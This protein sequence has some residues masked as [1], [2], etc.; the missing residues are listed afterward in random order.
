MN[1]ELFSCPECGRQYNVSHVPSCAR[2][3]CECGA[4]PKVYK[5]TPH[6]PRAL[7]CWNCGGSF[8]PHAHECSYCGSDFTI[9]E[10]RLNAVCP[11][12][13]GRMSI[14]AKFCMECGI[15][16]QPNAKMAVLDHDECPRCRADMRSREVENW[17]LIECTA[18]GGIWLAPGILEQICDA[19]EKQSAVF[20]WLNSRPAPQ[21]RDSPKKVIYLPCM[22]CDDRMMRRNFA[23][24]SG[25]IID[26]CK[27]DG[28]W[29]DHAELEK[30][31]SFVRRGG[32]A[33]ERALP[34]RRQSTTNHGVATVPHV[35][36]LF[37]KW[38]S[39]I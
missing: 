28:L 31:V 10:K 4:R 14:D 8:E 39:R 1:L 16:I 17:S 2:I 6:A 34:A 32:L 35:F 33:T 38:L 13:F 19:T 15:A 37:H 7:N 24:V 11:K 21:Y 27:N 25:V 29:L 5:K 22:R 20:D 23:G 36:E 26:I 30:I 12:C 18:C 9:E 3:C